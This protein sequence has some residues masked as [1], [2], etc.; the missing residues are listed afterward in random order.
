M[1]KTLLIFIFLFPIALLVC[2]YFYLRI[3]NLNKEISRLKKENTNYAQA[4]EQNKLHIKSLQSQ[5]QE[6]L[7]NTI[8]GLQK[9][10]IE[11]T[12]NIKATDVYISAIETAQ[13]STIRT[14]VFWAN[15]PEKTL[16]DAMDLG[17]TYEN[18]STKPEC[19]T[20]DVFSQYPLININSDSLSITGVAGISAEKIATGVI[21]KRFVSCT[22]VKNNPAK[23]A[24]IKL[25]T[26]KTSIYSLGKS[27]LNLEQSFKDIT[28]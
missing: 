7:Q 25:D 12:K 16:F 4:L 23:K 8:R 18:I 9:Q 1:K 27:I 11:S 21:N 17:I 2:T 28:W 3:N 13:S 14:V 10:Q 24:T 15:G 22:F 6:Q 5:T 26:T 19:T 20:G